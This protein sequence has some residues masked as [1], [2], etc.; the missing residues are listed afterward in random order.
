[1]NLANQ[2][3]LLPLT[4]LLLSFTAYS[5]PYVVQGAP[6]SPPLTPFAPLT[7]YD[8]SWTIKADHPWGGGAPGTLDHLVSHCERFSHYFACEQTVNGK[9]V[10]LLTYTATSDS[11]KYNCRTLAPDGLAGGRGDMTLEGGHWTYLDKPPLKL[12]GTWSRTENFILDQN[13]IR[14]EEYESSDEGKTW[15]QTNSGTEERIA[16][17]RSTKSTRN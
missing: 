6:M 2:I 13:H 15:V 1:M 10:S 5:E 11:A 3:F 12:K 7:I 9:T 17:F 16:S 4:L 14:F 8:G